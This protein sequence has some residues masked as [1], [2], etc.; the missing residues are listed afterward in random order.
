LQD[1]R[2]KAYGTP[3]EDNDL[4]TV[5]FMKQYIQDNFAALLE[6]YFMERTVTFDGG[7][8]GSHEPIA[9]VGKTKLV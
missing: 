8:A 1:G 9:V 7:D 4:V 5:A 3:L 6:N 2:A